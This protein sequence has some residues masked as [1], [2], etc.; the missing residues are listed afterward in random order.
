MEPRIRQYNI[1]VQ[2]VG[3]NTIG[4]PFQQHCQ[5]QKS[6]DEA[7]TPKKQV[8]T[9][10]TKRVD[11]KKPQT[12]GKQRPVITLNEKNYIQLVDNLTQKYTEASQAARLKQEAD[13]QSQQELGSLFGQINSDKV[14]IY[15]ANT[16]NNPPAPHTELE[17]LDFINDLGLSGV[18]EYVASKG[19]NWQTSKVSGRLRNE[20]LSASSKKIHQNLNDKNKRINLNLNTEPNNESTKLHLNTSFSDHTGEVPLESD[21]VITIKSFVSSEKENFIPDTPQSYSSYTACPR[22]PKGQLFPN[23][24]PKTSNFVTRPGNR[25]KISSLGGGFYFNTNKQSIPSA[26]YTYNREGSAARSANTSRPKQRQALTADILNNSQGTETKYFNIS[27]P[28]IA[29]RPSHA[30]HSHSHYY[31]RIF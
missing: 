24:K 22:C 31:H 8:Q 27:K 12:V 5:T 7:K 6:I 26:Y 23:R 29:P 16:N 1:P 25:G 4:H 9:S 19:Q 28:L 30:F 15:K 17:S 11:F 3:T 18:D 2:V 21:C 14:K 10:N 20:S 13:L